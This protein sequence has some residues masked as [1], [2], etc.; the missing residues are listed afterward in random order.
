MRKFL[1]AAVVAL[2]TGAGLSMAAAGPPASAE[3][4]IRQGEIAW[5]ESVA[6]GDPSAA[7][8]VLA[9]DFVG[10]NA[11]GTIS[12]KADE[13]KDLVSDAPQYASDHIDYMHVAF[14]GDAAV[15]QGSE[16]WV[17]KDGSRGRWVWVDMWAKRRGQWQIVNSADVN[18]PSLK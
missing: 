6:S 8:R 7:R 9:E 11:D 13:L 12:H 14:Y 15:V 16:T 5:T 1:F 2:T 3:Q 10:V 4:Y 18:A 17:K